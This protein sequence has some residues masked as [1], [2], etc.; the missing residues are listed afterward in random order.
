[1]SL[2]S[3]FKTGFNI[4]AGF[5]GFGIIMGGLVGAGFVATA[6]LSLPL[7]IAGAAAAAGTGTLA[8]VTCEVKAFKRF[9]RDAEKKAAKEENGPK[10]LKPVYKP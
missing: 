8:G 5:T 10:K 3:G 6:P 4:A 1:M 2:K 9:W 7:A